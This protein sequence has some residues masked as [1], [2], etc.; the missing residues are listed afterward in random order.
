MQTRF[1]PVVVACFSSH[2]VYAHVNKD[3]PPITRVVT[4]TINSCRC[5]HGWWS[6]QLLCPAQGRARGAAARRGAVERAAGAAHRG[7]LTEAFALEQ[8]TLEVEDDVGGLDRC[9]VDLTVDDEDDEDEAALYVEPPAVVIGDAPNAHEADLPPPRPLPLQFRGLGVASG[10][11]A[12]APVRGSTTF[13]WCGGGP[14]WSNALS[15]AFNRPRDE[16]TRV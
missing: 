13:T 8:T 14:E 10:G 9:A 12:A 3:Y 16:C 1:T 4:T 6:T 7:Q 15:D 5:H 11:S 2:A